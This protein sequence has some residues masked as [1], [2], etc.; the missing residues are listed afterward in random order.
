MS[1]RGDHNWWSAPKIL[2]GAPL[3]NRLELVAGPDLNQV[4]QDRLGFGRFPIFFTGLL[5]GLIPDLTRNTKFHQSLSHM[6]LPMNDS[7]T[8]V[9]DGSVTHCNCSYSE[10]KHQNNKYDYTSVEWN[11]RKA[12]R[13]DS[14][15][16]PWTWILQVDSFLKTHSRKCFTVQALLRNKVF[17]PAEALGGCWFEMG[18]RS[19]WVCINSRSEQGFTLQAKKT[20]WAAA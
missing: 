8:I 4:I 14:S 1:T 11:L 9:H 13:G 20:P 12:D 2:I 6:T 19:E 10:V 5:W 16:S 18:T 3:C 17:L 15:S 7:N